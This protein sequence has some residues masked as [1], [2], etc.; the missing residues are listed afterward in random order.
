MEALLKV[1]RLTDSAKLPERGTIGSAGL[2]IYSD[3]IEPYVYI[4]PG[5]TKKLATG[6]AV[7]IPPCC[8]GLFLD[9]GSIGSKSIHNYAGV[10]DADYRGELFVFLHNSGE[11]PMQILPGQKITQ[12]VIVPFLSLT[13]Y[14]VQELSSTVRGN[15]SFGSTGAF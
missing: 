10:I 13:P 7:E 9:K 1:K 8:V 11:E 15:G 4:N 14:E 2:D 5:E 12:L 3:Q 6:I